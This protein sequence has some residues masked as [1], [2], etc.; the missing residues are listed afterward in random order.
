MSDTV[1]VVVAA[2]APDV[3]AAVAPDV[4]APGPDV[5]VADILYYYCV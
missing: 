4:L 1:L 5:L 2:V 3:L